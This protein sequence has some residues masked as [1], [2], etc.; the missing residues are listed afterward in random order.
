MTDLNNKKLTLV[1]VLIAVLVAA[2]IAQSVVI[3]GLHKRVEGTSMVEQAN[4]PVAEQ[5]NPVAVTQDDED[6]KTGTLLPPVLPF[7][8]DF[9]GWGKDDWDPFKEMHSM[10]DRINQM[11]GSAFNRFQSSDNF[12]GVFGNYS[13]SPD[14]NIEDKDDHY[15][16]TVDLPGVEKSHLDVKIAGQTLT[17]SGNMQTESKEEDGGTILRQERRSGSFQRVVTL[18][19][20]VKSGAMETEEKNGVIYIEIPKDNE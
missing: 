3:F 16:I 19:G 18:P 11:F 14:I 4:T 20:P 2:V 12:G 15:L 10:H 8:D 7:D 1:T 6:G 5:E 17:I 9:F 13:F